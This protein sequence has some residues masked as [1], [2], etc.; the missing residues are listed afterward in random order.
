MG[1][2]SFWFW[3]L[4]FWNMSFF[5]FILDA[6]F[7]GKNFF[8]F[9]DSVWL[10]KKSW[11]VNF[12]STYRFYWLSDRCRSGIALW[13]FFVRKKLSQ[14]GSFHWLL[15]LATECFSVL[16]SLKYTAT[17]F[18]VLNA[19][20]VCW[21]LMG[22]LGF[23]FGFRVSEICLF[24]VFILDAIFCGTNFFIFQ[25]SVWLVKKSW[26]F[27]AAPFIDS[28]DLAIVAEADLRCGDFCPKQVVTNW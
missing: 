3:S 9:Q 14:I 19:F 27:I 4:C 1:V 24:F 6:I 10:V 13:W 23:D 25:D 22:V 7:C 5:V 28:T 8:I 2:P 26:W 12:C 18:W 11:C 17:L 16:T 21:S 20:W 15:L